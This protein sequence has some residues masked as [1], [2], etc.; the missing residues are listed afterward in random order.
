[1]CRAERLL[2]RLNRNT[3]DGLPNRGAARVPTKD[4]SAADNRDSDAGT[5]GNDMV[6]SDMG[7]K[8]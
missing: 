8:A 6:G 5:K 2:P 7:G 4:D 3:P 1:M